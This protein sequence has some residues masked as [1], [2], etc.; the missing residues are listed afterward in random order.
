M[1]FPLLPRMFSALFFREGN[2]SQPKESLCVCLCNI[3]NFIRVSLAFGKILA[4]IFLSVHTIKHPF[5]DRHTIFPKKKILLL[6][7]CVFFSWSF[8]ALNHTH[9]FH[10]QSFAPIKHQMCRRVK[11]F[12][13]SWGLFNRN[14]DLKCIKYVENVRHSIA[15][16]F[17]VV[18]VQLKSFHHRKLTIFREGFL[19]FFPPPSKKKF[20]VVCAM[21][22]RRKNSATDVKKWKDPCWIL[23]SDGEKKC[24]KCRKKE[25]NVK[26]KSFRQT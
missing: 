17:Q 20:N 1:V 6:S 12:F 15:K 10:S 24:G 22:R 9:I 7:L 25:K 8:R 4:V 18:R 11:T 2:I 26:M 19:V 5:I 23:E 16:V 3:H 13:A 14:K 21:E